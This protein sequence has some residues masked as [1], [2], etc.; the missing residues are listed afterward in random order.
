ML[1]SRLVVCLLKTF[2]VFHHIFIDFHGFVADWLLGWLGGRPG[3]RAVGVAR[4]A[5]RSVWLLGFVGRSVWLLGFVGMESPA[6]D[7]RRGQRT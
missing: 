7:A 3:H 1:G 4:L 5:G 6:L 2:S